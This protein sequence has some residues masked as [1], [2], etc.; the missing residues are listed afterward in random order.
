MNYSVDSKFYRNNRFSPLLFLEEEQAKTS[1]SQIGTKIR[2]NSPGSRQEG[3]S[4]Q[5][6]QPFSTIS[7]L[8]PPLTPVA[9]TPTSVKVEQFAKPVMVDQAVQYSFEDLAPDVQYPLDTKD[10]I[11]MNPDLA[12][13]G[14]PE[15]LP[16]DEHAG[17]L[18]SKDGYITRAL[19]F[20][21]DTLYWSAYTTQQSIRSF[22]TQTEHELLLAL[23]DPN[24]QVRVSRSWIFGGPREQLFGLSN[25]LIHTILVNWPKIFYQEKFPRSDRFNTLALL[26]VVPHVICDKVQEVTQET[27]QRLETVIRKAAVVLTDPEGYDNKIYL[28]KLEKE[29]V[30]ALREVTIATAQFTV[31]KLDHVKPS[32]EKAAV[33]LNAAI[34]RNFP[35]GGSHE[36]LER[37]HIDTLKI[38]ME[39]SFRMGS[40]IALEVIKVQDKIID[41][42]L[43]MPA[44]TLNDRKA[45]VHFLAEQLIN[46][47]E[48]SLNKVDQFHVLLENLDKTVNA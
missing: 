39:R 15:R 44:T 8:T 33:A 25:G 35:Y 14:A 41:Q 4:F 13:Q 32:F 42:F 1:K 7:P 16:Y 17:A 40:D 28:D 2:S 3:R 21:A 47:R 5:P 46:L 34:E 11:V 18:P 23:G 27:S 19:K 10:I 36:D 45:R 20:F 31:N 29:M 38:I 12:P 24:Q 22:F 26:Q 37:Y 6:I 43:S 30:D 9:L 48:F